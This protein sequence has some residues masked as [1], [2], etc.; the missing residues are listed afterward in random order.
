[1][2][3]ITPEEIAKTIVLEI[4]GANTGR[5]VL[6]AMDASV[7]NPSYKAGLLRTTAIT[8]LDLAEKHSGIPL[9][10]WVDLDRLSCQS[11]LR[12]I[13]SSMRFSR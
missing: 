8:D 3:Y 6:S 12:P 2:E 11:Y 9:L 1:M 7:L 5:D 4:C 10:P 13:C